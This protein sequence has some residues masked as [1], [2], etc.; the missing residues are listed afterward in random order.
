MWLFWPFILGTVIHLVVPPEPC[1]SVGVN[2][3]EHVAVRVFP[4]Y[5]ALVALITQQLVHIVPQQSALW[6]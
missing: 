1:Q 4:P 6:S 3:T 2:Y 5:V